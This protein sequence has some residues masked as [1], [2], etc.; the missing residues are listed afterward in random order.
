MYEQAQALQPLAQRATQA[1]QSK[2]GLDDAAIAEIHRKAQANEAL[3]QQAYQTTGD[4]AQ[5]YYSAFETILWADPTLRQ[6][7]IEHEAA[8]T[9]A[10]QQD[11]NNRKARAGSLAGSGGS[12][13]RQ[14]TPPSTPQDRNAA[15]V[16]ELRAAMQQR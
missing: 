2:Y 16:A 15:I 10:A 12:V 8:T 14:S 3:L 5:A 13:P 11:I 1:F 4:A 6:R 7:A 9:V